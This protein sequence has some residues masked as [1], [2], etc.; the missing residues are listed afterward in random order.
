MRI[1]SIIP[2][3]KR[4]FNHFFAIAF[5]ETNVISLAL[6]ASFKKNSNKG[7]CEMI[8]NLDQIIKETRII[9]ILRGVTAK[10]AERTVDALIDG[11]IKA[12]EITLTTDDALDALRLVCRKY[13]RDAVIG[14]G[15][16]LTCDETRRVSDAGGRFIVSP[17]TDAEVVRFTKQLGLASIPGAL[18]PSEIVAAVQ[19][20]ADYVKLFP[21]GNMG[22][23]YFKSLRGPFPKIPFVVTGAINK[24]NLAD[25]LKAGAVGAGIGGNLINVEKIEQGDFAYITDSAR[26]YI[27][28]ARLD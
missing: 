27:E 16:V 9:A 5:V 15:T 18:T 7:I 10:H 14:A 24:D 3:N 19:A 11:G 17:N 28:K 26:E 22:L 6:T 1:Q 13:D 4:F 20:G 23:A 12:L 8:S 25:Y 2:C 21:A